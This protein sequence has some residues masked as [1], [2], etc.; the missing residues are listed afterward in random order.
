MLNSESPHPVSLFAADF[1]S[2][3]DIFRSTFG[4]GPTT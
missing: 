3:L 2:I 4:E 1:V